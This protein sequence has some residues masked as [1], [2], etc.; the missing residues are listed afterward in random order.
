MLVRATMRACVY[1]CMRASRQTKE[2]TLHQTG[3][4]ARWP[5]RSAPAFKK[6]LEQMGAA[7]N[8]YVAIAIL[9][10]PSNSSR[11]MENALRLSVSRNV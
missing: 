8:K 6:D 9:A 5:D 10:T 7:V 1:A 2:D 3:E 4:D 11:E